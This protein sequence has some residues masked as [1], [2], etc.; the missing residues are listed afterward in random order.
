MKETLVKQ[1]ESE[2]HQ[3]FA[4]D[5]DSNLATGERSRALRMRM[6]VVFTLGFP[7]SKEQMSNPE[8]S[9]VSSGSDMYTGSEQ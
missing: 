7:Q 8:S 1:T 3:E 6:A 2:I 4:F 9:F 5:S